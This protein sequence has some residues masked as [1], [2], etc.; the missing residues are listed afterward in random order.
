PGGRGSSDRLRESPK[1]LA[2][3][4]VTTM[5]RPGM[6]D[7]H[8]ALPTYSRPSLIIPPQLGVGGWT[9]RPR[10]D[11]DDSTM[12]SSASWKLETTMAGPTTLGAMWRNTILSPL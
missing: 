9:P 1:R 6:A 7:S 10:N 2:P 8:H 5:A 12:I 3:S 11:S 4:T